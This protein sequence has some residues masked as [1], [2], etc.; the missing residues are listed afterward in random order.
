MP[1]ILYHGQYRI[2]STRLDNWDYGGSGPYFVTICTLGKHPFL[3]KIENGV[4][5]LTEIGEIAVDQLLKTSIIWPN[6]DLDEWVAMPDHVH[7]IIVIKRPHVETPSEGVSFPSVSIGNKTPSE[8]VS[9]K[10]T[11]NDKPKHWSA[12]TLGVIINQYKRSCTVRIREIEPFFMW[13]PRYYDRII[14]D[15]RELDAVR[16]YIRNNP[17]KSGV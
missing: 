11:I 8:G 7:A 14:R 12:G 4:V 5:R 3:G 2:P 13:Q 17:M 9:T 1:D 6:V 16:E 15:E 10:Y